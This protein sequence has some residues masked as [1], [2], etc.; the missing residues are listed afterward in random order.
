MFYLNCH[1][2]GFVV[3]IL[4][5]PTTLIAAMVLLLNGCSTSSLKPPD[6]VSQAFAARYPNTAATWEPKPYGYEA[7]FHHNGIEYEAEFSAD[8]HWL[9]TEHEVSAA[10]FSRTVLERIQ[11]EYPGYTITKYEIE[12]TPQGTFYEVEIEQ[13]DSEYELYFDASATPALNANE[14]S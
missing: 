5:H 11:R 8:G 10:A 7:T 9:E 2:Q 4:R 1:P 6:A 12:Q 3:S 13:A 14:D